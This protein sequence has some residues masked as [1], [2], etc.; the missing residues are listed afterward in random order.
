MGN[1]NF[2]N[3]VKDSII[4]VMC[5]AYLKTG[6]P[7]LLHQ[8]THKL[9]DN[10]FDAIICYYDCIDG[11]NNYTPSDFKKYVDKF[12]VESEIIDT[13]KNLVIFPET[14]I[15]S[16]RNFNNIRK[17]FWWLSVDNYKILFSI[18]TRYE[19]LGVLGVIAFFVK[20]RF[21]NLLYKNDIHKCDYHLCQ[22]YYSIDYLKSLG[23][24][25][26]FYLSDYLSKE[27]F[28]KEDNI[29]EDIIL[30]NPK[31][32][33]KFT[34]KLIK[35]AP[36]LNWTPIQNL[37]SEEVSDLLHSSKV[38]IDFGNHPGKDRLP[39]EACVSGCC[40][41]TGKKGSA[42]YYDDV[43]IEDEFKFEDSGENIP[44]I[45][46]KIEYLLDNFDIE[47]KKFDNYRNKIKNE[48]KLFEE[49]LGKIFVKI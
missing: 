8:L 23:I 24:T 33:F 19:L 17:V 20:F 9:N 43:M 18:K 46:D 15:K 49:D 37:T 48:E 26:Y 44:L 28:E 6:G 39:R 36:H 27:F 38:Y 40:I 11:N 42:K 29:K 13:S 34:Q 10:G 35:N 45:I 41:I 22:S 4:Y 14:N 7:E 12:V 3:I 25:N 31:K 47:T 16:I 2:I 1:T 30:Y 32:G 21:L 5:P